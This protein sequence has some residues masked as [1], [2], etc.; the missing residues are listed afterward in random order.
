MNYLIGVKLPALH[1]FDP[2]IHV[3]NFLKRCL[4]WHVVMWTLCKATTKPSIDQALA[5]AEHVCLIFE[6]S[7]RDFGSTDF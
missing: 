6:R 4:V 5:L 7:A 3:V 1:P 2:Y